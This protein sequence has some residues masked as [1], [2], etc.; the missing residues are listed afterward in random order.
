MRKLNG[1]ALAAALSLVLVS[2]AANA[3]AVGV[4]R[5]PPSS[6]GGNG[7]GPPTCVV[8]CVVIASPNNPPRRPDCVRVPGTLTP[9]LAGRIIMRHPCKPGSD[10]AACG[11]KLGNLR[12]VTAGQVQRIDDRDDVH[13]VPICDN[14]NRSLTEDEMN[15]LARGNVQG[16]LRPIGQNAR[17]EA[18]LG[19]DGYRADDVLGIVLDPHMV[20]LYVSRARAGR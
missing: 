19:D 8:D 3:A 14:P 4:F 6:P 11:R 18:A 16:L 10:V 5:G 15:F 9:V 12:R 17:L 1:F 7:N 20:T 13:L 2:T